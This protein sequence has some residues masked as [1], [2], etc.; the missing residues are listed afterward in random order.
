MMHCVAH[1]NLHALFPLRTKVESR[2]SVCVSCNKCH[3]GVTRVDGAR[4]GG[5]MM[6]NE[7]QGDQGGA[8]AEPEKERSYAYLLRMARPELALAGY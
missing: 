7:E 3:K 2:L 6:E 4:S 8:E 1:A 5:D